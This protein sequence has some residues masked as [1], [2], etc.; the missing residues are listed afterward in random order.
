MR[1]ASSACWPPATVMCRSTSTVW[2]AS[3]S[4]WRGATSTTILFRNNSREF[5][6]NHYVGASHPPTQA[7]SILGHAERSSQE[8]VVQAIGCE[9]SVMTTYI[10]RRLMLVPVLLFGV[11]VL[12]FSMLQFLTPVERSALYVRDLPRNH[13]QLEGIILRYGLDKPLPVTYWNWVGGTRNPVTG[14]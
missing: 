4:T 10:L 3:P 12:I 5:L 7:S 6:V 11:T 9:A 13:R 14:E 1:W 2:I 8:T